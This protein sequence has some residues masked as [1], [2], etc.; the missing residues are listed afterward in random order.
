MKEVS[1]NRLSILTDSSVVKCSGQTRLDVL[2]VLWVVSDHGH[3]GSLGDSLL[4]V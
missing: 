1:E 2:L 4:V 3:C